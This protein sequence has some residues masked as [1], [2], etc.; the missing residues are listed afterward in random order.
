MGKAS[1]Q[2]F[3][4]FTSAFGLDAS[5]ITSA[6]DANS[7]SS[8]TIPSIRL[9]LAI[10]ESYLIRVLLKFNPSWLIWLAVF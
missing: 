5:L 1:D 6:K 9:Q 10:L 2:E 7:L 4:T 8:T 3:L